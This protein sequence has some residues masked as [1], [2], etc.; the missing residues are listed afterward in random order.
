LSAQRFVLAGGFSFVFTS[1]V[2]AQSLF[3]KPVKILGDPHFIGTAANPLLA[4]SFGPNAIEGRELSQPLGIA[5]DTSSASPIVYIADTGNN[6]VLAF[7]SGSQI[8]PGSNADLVL[9]QPDPFTNRAHGPDGSFST[10]LSSPTGLAVDASGNL[11]VADSGDNRVLRYPKPFAQPAGYQVPDLI[12]GQSSFAG[13]GANTGGVKATTLSLN[14]GKTGL[15]FDTA[16]NLWVTDTGNNRVLRFPAALLKTGQNGPAADLAVGQTDLL[17]SL[18]VTTRNSKT[19]LVRPTSVCFD[20]AGRMLVADAAARLVVYPAGVGANVPAIRILGIATATAAQPNPPV[21]SEISVT[22]VVSAT[23]VGT[24]IVVVDSADNRLLVYP[25]VDSWPA[26]TTQFS[27]SATSVVGQATFLDSK[28]NKG[29]EPSAVALSAPFDVAVA[30]GQLFAADSGNNRVLVFPFG[31]SGVSA[32]SLVI[33]QVNFNSAAPNLV[34]GKEFGFAGAL[35]AASGSVVLDLSATPP[36]LYVADTLNNR[37]LGFNDFANA[38]NGQRADIVIGQP[39]FSR[40]TI[41]YP[42]NDGNL[43][44]SQGLNGPTGLALDSAGNLYVADT[45]NSRILRFP[46][47]FAS[48]ILTL[49]TADLVLGQAN[50]TSSVPDATD[51]T[52]NAPVSLAFSKDGADNSVASGGYLLAADANQNRVLFFQKPFSNGMSAAKILGQPG[53]TSTASSADVQRFASPRGVAMDPQDRVLVADTGNGRVQ[54]FDR[55]QNLANYATASFSLS[56]GLSQ[57]VAIAMSQNGQFWVAD[58]STQ[59]RLLHFPAVD[60]LPLKNYAAD[61]ALPAIS[62]RSAFV[63]QYNNMVVADG[64]DR[65]LYFAPQ[66]SVVNAANYIPG[67]ALAPGAFAAIFPAPATPPNPIANGTDTAAAFPLPNELADTQVIVNNNIAPLLYVSPGQIN[68]PLS[69]TLPNGGSV[70]LEVVRVSTGQVYG[71]A[72]ISL[73]SASPGL[74]TIGGSGTG[75]VAALNEDNSINS[76]TNQALRGHPIQLFG[77]GQGFVANAPPDGQA[78]TGEV[79]TASTPRIQLGSTFIP[80][81]NIQYSGLAPFLAG[82]WQINFTIPATTPSGNNI[83]IKILMNSV[84]SDNPSSPG[85]IATTI[86][87]K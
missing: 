3:V 11:Y 21:V 54:V 72:E 66:V 35:N 71:G 62:P 13:T 58:A 38:K 56:A 68:I 78:S 44:N 15:A 10:G 33:G 80:D 17:S 86:G 20:T 74:F 64:I 23:A 57:P 85:Q 77:T 48:G 75:Q 70:D 43:P 4:D 47:P 45:F 65:I 53:F 69:L 24:S 5:L 52:M 34:E 31:P 60:Q 8:M 30:G 59:N 63:D 50:F 87:I 32:A 19:G 36:H 18:A 16:G 29:G 26:E 41:N 82:V 51:R 84:P 46:A 25:S 2:L 37:I 55:V 81:A 79:P 40:T 7:Q 49:E 39:D 1:A 14:G 22:S 73:N 9:G 76:A 12:V 28:A 6:R 27:P 61:A 67:R 83:P 42:S